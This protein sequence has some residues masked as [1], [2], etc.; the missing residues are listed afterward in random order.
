MTNR[1]ED[2][3]Q[4]DHDAWSQ[5]ETGQYNAQHFTAEARRAGLTVVDGDEHASGLRKSFADA[6]SAYLAIRQADCDDNPVGFAFTP[7]ARPPQPDTRNTSSQSPAAAG[8]PREPATPDNTY[9][10]D[11]LPFMP[12]WKVG[13]GVENLV[14]P[15]F[16]ILRGSPTKIISSLRQRHKLLLINAAEKYVECIPRYRHTDFR[17]KL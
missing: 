5:W 7:V 2:S 11:N 13:V 4:T 14:A 17:N 10:K 12:T 8:I 9:T 1:V 3:A 16:S 6:A 15:P